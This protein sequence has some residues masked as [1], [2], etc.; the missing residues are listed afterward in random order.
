MLTSC[1]L[2]GEDMFGDG[3][4]NPLPRPHLHHTRGELA[5]LWCLF[6]CLYVLACACPCS[7]VCLYLNSDDLPR[8]EVLQPGDLETLGGVEDKPAS[9]P[10]PDPSGAVSTKSL[11]WRLTGGAPVCNAFSM[12]GR[13]CSA[14]FK[15]PPGAVKRSVRLTLLGARPS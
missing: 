4:V 8:Q 3:A 7:C 15:K 12:A 13:K 5:A 14:P 9:S 11:W 2:D 10:Y 6:N 1:V